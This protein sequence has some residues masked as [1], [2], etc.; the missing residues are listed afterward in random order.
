MWEGDIWLWKFLSY[1]L[2]LAS[3]LLPLLFSRTPTSDIESFTGGSTSGS[4]TSRWN[5]LSYF[6]PLASCLLPLASCLLL[7]F[8][9]L[10][11]LSSRHETQKSFSHQYGY[12]QKYFICFEVWFVVLKSLFA[13]WKSRDPKKQIGLQ[14]RAWNQE[15]GQKN[16]VPVTF[17]TSNSSNFF[18]HPPTR[19]SFLIPFKNF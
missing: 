3:Y 6:L 2:P 11:F 1:F 9:R 5:F 18:L 15:S 16:A 17:Q 7:L 8:S 14:K 10:T 12:A 4:A 13:I 19:F